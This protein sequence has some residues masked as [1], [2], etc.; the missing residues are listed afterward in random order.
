MPEVEE[1]EVPADAEMGVA[2]EGS[3]DWWPN[4]EG[5]VALAELSP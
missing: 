4:E 1:L 2:I 5:E 3:E